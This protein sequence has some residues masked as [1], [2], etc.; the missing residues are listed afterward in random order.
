MLKKTEWKAVRVK[1]RGH[2]FTPMSFELKHVLG[3]FQRAMNVKF[4]TIQWSLFWWSRRHLLFLE[5]PK[6]YVRKVRQALAF[7]YDTDITM[8]LRKGDLSGCIFLEQRPNGPDEQIRY[9]YWALNDT[10]GSYNIK[11]KEYFA[12][13]C[14]ILLPKPYLKGI[15]STI[16]TGDDALRRIL[17]F[18]VASE[19]LDC[20]CLRFLNLNLISCTEKG[21]NIKLCTHFGDSQHAQHNPAKQSVTGTHDIH[22]EWR[23]GRQVKCRKMSHSTFGA[24][25][26]F[27]RTFCCIEDWYCPNSAY[28]H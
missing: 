15:R 10:K 13:V 21:S 23:K 2:Q 19:E 25:P 16:R 24:R 28:W 22:G 5:E 6:S 26:D 20:K 27:V 1:T 7:P 4:Y 11:Q 14:A 12:A 18:T 9:S 3:I 8:K 17:K